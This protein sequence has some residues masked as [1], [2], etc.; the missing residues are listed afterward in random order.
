MPR[1][2]SAQGGDWESDPPR[3]LVMWSKRIFT[4]L[5]MLGTGPVL[6]L[7][8]L[9]APQVGGNYQELMCRFCMNFRVWL[10]IWPPNSI[11]SRYA[12]P[13]SR[14]KVQTNFCSI[15]HT[16]WSLFWRSHPSLPE[17]RLLIRWKIQDQWSCPAL[18]PL[19]VITWCSTWKARTVSLQ[20]MILVLIGFAM[21][22]LTS[23]RD[24]NA[25]A[26]TTLKHSSYSLS[27]SCLTALSFRGSVARMD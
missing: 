16:G 3:T 11:L 10:H 27:V 17:K 21:T 4:L 15:Q 22:Q 23:Y 13:K 1:Q 18:A 25:L 2:D 12:T 24:K 19:P 14:S 9:A 8:S 6:V 26:R 7:Q 20:P 5:M